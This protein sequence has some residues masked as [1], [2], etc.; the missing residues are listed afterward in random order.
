[1]APAIIQSLIG[2]ATG[3]ADASSLGP[4]AARAVL[5]ARNLVPRK[6]SG[7]RPDPSR[8]AVNPHDINNNAVFALFGL[9][10]AGFVIGG[11]W[12]FFWAKNGGFYFKENDWDDYKSTVLRRTGPNG[13][14]LSNVTKS[15][16]LGGGS[17]YK[18][19]DDGTTVSGGSEGLL[20]GHRGRYHDDDARTEITD[21]TYMTGITAGVSDIGAREKRRKKKEARDRERER[22]REEKAR[23]KQEEKDAKAGNK[24]R[25]KVG[26]DGALID[27]EAEAEAAEQL[28]NYRHEKPARVGGLN[29]E[30]EGSQWDGSNPSGSSAGTR[31]EVSEPM[32]SRHRSHRHQ[33]SRQ[34]E[35]DEGS[36]VTSELLGGDKQR[37]SAASAPKKSS[38]GG[39]T[40]GIRKV[41]ST[42]DKVHSREQERIRAE[43][44]RLQEKGRSA[45]AASTVASSSAASSSQASSAA[46]APPRRDY[47]FQRGPDERRGFAMRRIEEAES[48]VASAADER[49]NRSKSRTR[50][51]S[52]PPTDPAAARQ[53]AS[54]PGS[55]VEG[56]EVGTSSEVG[57]KT[58]H[59]PIPELTGSSLSGSGIATNDFAYQDD[60]R[61]SRRGGGGGGGERSGDRDRSSY[62]RG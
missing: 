28:R 43:A 19:V 6:D 32:P 3:A 14:I 61:K 24:S 36:G 38:G 33:R 37:T 9:I 30:S 21:D 51:K 57:T 15:T 48:S 22:Q 20:R 39:N 29:K 12:F 2:R 18:D 10:G 56:S 25:R 13:T 35:D 59:H 47:S 50:S 34:D 4:L 17:V 23:R 26:A 45:M 44:R 40:G 53:S 7:E 1:M 60:K 11:I 31:T 16:K 52:R 58:Y 27:A 41:Y 62:R 55:W 42:A 46:A 49:R 54:V 8:G 5:T